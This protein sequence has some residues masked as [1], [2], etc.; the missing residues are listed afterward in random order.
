[1]RQ[2]RRN[3]EAEEQRKAAGV[4][5]SLVQGRKEFDRLMREFATYLK[6]RGA[7]RSRVKAI[8]VGQQRLISPSGWEMPGPVGRPALLLPSGT[9]LT[10]WSKYGSFSGTAYK[11]M[12]AAIGPNP[13]KGR[14]QQVGEISYVGGDF[15]RVRTGEGNDSFTRVW[16]ERVVEL[17]S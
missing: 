14:W 10:I 16:K 17:T 5:S 15:V 8:D 3:A 4:A 12:P 9:L 13:E 11:F 6:S 1:M 7:K 2:T